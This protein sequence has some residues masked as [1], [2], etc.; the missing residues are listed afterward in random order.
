MQNFYRS[1]Q[2]FL[3]GARRNGALFSLMSA[4]V[5]TFSLVTHVSAVQRMVLTEGY[6][7]YQ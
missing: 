2:Q 4:L 1:C 3:T 6:T 7:N 5:L